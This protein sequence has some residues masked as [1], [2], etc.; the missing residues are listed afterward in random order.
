MFAVVCCVD[1][2]PKVSLFAQMLTWRIQK[3]DM[4]SS[5]STASS[6]KRTKAKRAMAVGRARKTCAS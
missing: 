6:A 5:S 3:V 2:D 1:F 4:Q